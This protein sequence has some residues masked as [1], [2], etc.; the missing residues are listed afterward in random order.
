M[1]TIYKYPLYA[2]TQTLRMP[3][4]AKPLFIS[5]QRGAPYMWVE[6]ETEHADET[7][8]ITTYATGERID[9]SDRYIGS[10]TL[11][12]GEE[13]CHVYILEPDRR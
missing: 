7:Y 2:Y 10:Y 11:D 6:V 8:H 12:N 3:A 1:R 9:S 5:V 13:V 4:G